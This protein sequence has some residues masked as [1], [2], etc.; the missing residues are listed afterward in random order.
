MAA[1]RRHVSKIFVKTAKF[2]PKIG[3][4]SAVVSPRVN[5][6]IASVPSA[7]LSKAKDR[8]TKQKNTPNI[9]AETEDSTALNCIKTRKIRANSSHDVI[10]PQEFRSGFRHANYET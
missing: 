9:K 7:V 6:Q 4:V 3:L 8:R 1:N 5:R 2:S 10:R